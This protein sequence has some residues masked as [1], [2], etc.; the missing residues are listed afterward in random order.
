M[1]HSLGLHWPD[2]ATSNMH[3]STCAKS[4]K[5]FSDLQIQLCRKKTSQQAANL[6]P[7]NERRLCRPGPAQTWCLW[8]PRH[9]AK[10]K[11]VT[12]NALTKDIQRLETTRW[13]QRV[14]QKRKSKNPNQDDQ[15]VSVWRCGATFRQQN[16]KAK[17]LRG[18]ERYS[19]LLLFALNNPVPKL[20]LLTIRAQEGKC[21]HH[22]KLLQ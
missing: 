3:E 18:L 15:K 21:Q 17:D 14:R 8:R 20:L 6:C 9:S 13:N 22:R 19:F 10:H 12:T 16:V 11:Q 1:V 2:W 7:P 4:E 5:L